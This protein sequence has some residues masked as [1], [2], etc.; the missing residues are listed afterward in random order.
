MQDGQS[1]SRRFAG[2]GLGDAHQVPAGEKFGNGPR[3]N[4]RGNNVAPCFQGPLDG[5][6]EAEI[7]EI[8]CGQMAVPS[9][10]GPFDA[11]NGAKG[12]ST[13]EKVGRKPCSGLRA[14]NF[15]HLKR[16]ANQSEDSVMPSLR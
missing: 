7:R 2:A 13:V 9:K 14:R 6:G 1:E 5:F 4:R 16:N 10:C 12:W 8:T 15:L 11:G 3:L